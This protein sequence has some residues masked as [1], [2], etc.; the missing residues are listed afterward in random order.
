[1]E[2]CPKC[3]RKSWNPN[4]SK[5]CEC[6]VEK[7]KDGR[8]I[9]P[10][11]GYFLDQNGNLRTPIATEFRDG[12]LSVTYAYLLE[13]GATTLRGDHRKLADAPKC[14]YPTRLDCNGGE[15]YARCEF[16]EYSGNHNL[17]GS[18]WECMAGKKPDPRTTRT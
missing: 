15:G 13:D 10:P 3:G 17:Y 6:K 7:T 18:N 5:C 8:F 4:S 2:R 12:R 16:M 14:T 1:M 11:S 9:V